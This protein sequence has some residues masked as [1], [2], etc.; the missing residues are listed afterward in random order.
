MHHNDALLK[1]KIQYMLK[2]WGQFQQ[3]TKGKKN[4]K[5]NTKKRIFLSS[6]QQNRL[7][8]VNQIPVGNLEYQ[9]GQ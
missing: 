8:E 6:L 9:V 2:I 4:R 1:L 7:Q 5:H 3:Q